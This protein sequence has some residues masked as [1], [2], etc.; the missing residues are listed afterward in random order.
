MTSR[1]QRLRAYLADMWSRRFRP[2]AHDC[3]SFALGWVA[4][5]TGQDHYAR[6]RGA[7]RSM[8]QLD[9]VMQAAGFPDHI[10]YV[11][12]VMAEIPPAMAQTGDLAVV[13]G[14][15]LGIVAQDRVFVLRPDGSGHVSRMEAVR[16]F[17][18]WLS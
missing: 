14:K 2:G 13:Q 1:A 16:A 15:A 4:A 18:T 11:Q 10:A 7:Y 9:D 8:E 17:K 5:E 3:G 12:S 6:W